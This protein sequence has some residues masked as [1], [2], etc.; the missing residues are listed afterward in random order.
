MGWAIRVI[1]VI[2]CILMVA[3]LFLSIPTNLEPEIE[4]GLTF[5]VITMGVNLIIGLLAL[6]KFS[7]KS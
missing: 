5:I 6:F 1:L 3:L 2:L 7:N 4:S